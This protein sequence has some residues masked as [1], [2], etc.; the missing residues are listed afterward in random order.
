MFGLFAKPNLS[1]PERAALMLTLVQ[2]SLMAYFKHHQWLSEDLRATV[3]ENWLRNNNRKA[4]IIFR[5]KISAAADE[6][7]RY[8]ITT[9]PKNEMR[10]LWEFLEHAQH[11][12]TGTNPEADQ[13]VFTLMAEC[14]KAIIAKGLAS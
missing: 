8:L 10:D 11:M 4:G 13:M 6:M 1:L 14:E 3:I 9:Q 12:T 5:S 7:A 2:A